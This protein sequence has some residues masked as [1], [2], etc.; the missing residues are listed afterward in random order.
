MGTDGASKELNETLR[1]IL[2][3]RVRLEPMFYSLP[4]HVFIFFAAVA[5]KWS[6]AQFE[7]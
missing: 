1:N 4:D 2:S 3:C 5:A 6:F 7:I